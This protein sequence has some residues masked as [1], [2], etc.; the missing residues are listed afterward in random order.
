[1]KDGY[2]VIGTDLDTKSFDA[3]IDYIKS[4]LQE[5]EELLEKA[6]MGFE[7]G[8]TL[9]LEAQYEK[10]TDKL[11]TLIQKKEEF[12]RSKT[13]DLSGITKATD[14]VIKQ[15]GKWGLALFGIRTAYSFIRGTISQ[16]TQQ[17]Q[18]LANQ[19][20]YIKFAIGTAIK[21]IV[22]FIL[23]TVYKI[24]GV[25]GGII[26]A[27]TGINIFSKAT[28]NNFKN[29][30]NQAK[31]LKR[32]LA[33]FDEMNVLNSDGTVGVGIKFDVP[34]ITEEINSW[35]DKIKKWFLGEEYNNIWDSIKGNIKNLP[36][37]FKNT[38]KPFYS[39]I[40]K[41]YLIDPFLYSIDTLKPIWEPI[42]TNFE[43]AIDEVKNTWQDFVGMF[44]SDFF[45]PVKDAWKAFLKTLF[46]MFTPFINSMIDGINTAFGIWGV[47][48]DYIE[49]KE[50]E[51]QE[52][53]SDIDKM[54]FK[55][56]LIEISTKLK[57]N[58]NEA[59]NIINRFANFIIQVSKKLGGNLGEAFAKNIMNIAVNMFKN[60][61][62]TGKLAKGGIVYSGNLPKLASGGVINMPGMGV[63]YRGATI[64][65]RGAEAIV[66]LTDSQQMALLGEAIGKYVNL[67]ATIP[68]YVG[69]RQIARE[70]KKINADE[71]FAYNK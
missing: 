22:E 31:S 47:H 61:S 14:N 51:V 1:M 36:N 27:I 57:V 18:T 12:N 34:D 55:E 62:A 46:D 44:P 35:G 67:N 60:A 11:R 29:A 7:V 39:N 15:I 5:I 41:P 16:I 54:Q 2:V 63:P 28:A 21:P 65:E 40:L 58:T 71:D 49:Y 10:L 56:K 17:D 69:N 53:L 8:D 37:E 32:T 52:G 25:V 26:K 20:E 59:E 24:I 33:G 9:K 4:Q 68:V 50:G 3:Q 13:F 23:N 6:D 38:F 42:K 19:I 48:L 66:P 70:I 45:R 30:N 43:E 64:G